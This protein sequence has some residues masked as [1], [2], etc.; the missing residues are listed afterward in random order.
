MLMWAIYA[1]AIILAGLAAALAAG[2][3]GLALV[4]LVRFAHRSALFL[5][6]P[7]VGF[8]GY[9]VSRTSIYPIQQGFESGTI[10]GPSGIGAAALLFGA[11]AFVIA[12]CAASFFVCANLWIQSAAKTPNETN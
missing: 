11:Y 7:I 5:F 4:P 8:A 1:I 10:D 2:L 9:W 3:V 6:V 12:F